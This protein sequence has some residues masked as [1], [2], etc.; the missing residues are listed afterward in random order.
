MYRRFDG[1]TVTDKLVTEGIRLV[2][3]WDTLYVYN[4]RLQEYHHSMQALTKEGIQVNLEISVRW[5]PVFELVGLLHQ[6]IGPNYK[7]A[8][9]KPEVEATLRR[10]IGSHKV[11]DI[12]EDASTVGRRVLEQSLEKAQR[13]YVH[14]DEVLVRSVELPK[15]LR[16][17]ITAKLM[18]REKFL[19]YAHRINVAEEEKRRLL[20]EAEGI[21]NYN[22]K[23]AESLTAE[24]LQW[25][26]VQATKELAKSANAKTVVI[27][28]NSDGLPIILPK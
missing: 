9:I 3:P 19:T 4:V 17:R 5:R 18:E 8:V 22:K 23:V 20:I 26:A 11:A 14:I 16:D 10:I 7:D 21:K 1:G 27:G 12:Y 28:R 13:N 24:V 2:P 6:K 25:Q 15:E